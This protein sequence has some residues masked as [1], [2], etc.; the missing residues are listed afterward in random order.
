[1]INVK[2]DNSCD[3][4]QGSKQPFGFR[5]PQE[6]GRTVAGAARW[7]DDGGPTVGRG[8]AL[9]A[10]KPAWS[11]LSL[12]DLNESIR[13]ECDPDDAARTTRDFQRGD[14]ARRRDA[15]RDAER[16]ASSARAELNRDRNPW[17]H[18]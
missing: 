15:A 11:V 4:P 2:Y 1:M 17:E 12:R 14:G 7:D 18:T 9:F 16:A 13:R 8:P 10:H 6:L 5:S 3:T